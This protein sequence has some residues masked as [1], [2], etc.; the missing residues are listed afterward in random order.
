MSMADTI[1]TALLVVGVLVVGAFVVLGLAS[2]RIRRLLQQ[3][4]HDML[5]RDREQW[6]D[7]PPRSEEGDR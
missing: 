5:H 4:A 2:P 7:D 1:L 3:P 6:G